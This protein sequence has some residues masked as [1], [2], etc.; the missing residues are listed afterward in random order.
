M[1]AH[2]ITLSGQKKIEMT[3]SDY[4]SCKIKAQSQAC[5]RSESL[6]VERHL[7]DRRQVGHPGVKLLLGRRLVQA[8]SSPQVSVVGGAEA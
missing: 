8:Q 3:E 1:W 6:W 4:V 5:W 7:V 2:F